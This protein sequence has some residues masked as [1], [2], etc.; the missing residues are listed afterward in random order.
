MIRTLSGGWSATPASGSAPD[1][2]ERLR[3]LVREIVDGSSTVHPQIG[4]AE[5]R[6]AGVSA[7]RRGAVV[8]IAS[9]KGGVG[10][11]SIAVNLSIALA[12]QHLRVVLLDGDLGLGNA[13]VLCGLNPE[14]N[15]GDLVEGTAS[16]EDITLDAPGGFRLVPGASGI[17]SLADLDG[18]SRERMLACLAR[19]ETGAD[20]LMIDCGAGIG[21]SVRAFLLSSDLPLV[22]VTPDPTSITDAYALIKSLHGASGGRPAA[23]ALVVNQARDREEAAGV[24]RRIDSVCARFLGISV[25]LAGWLRA[26]SEVAR[27]VRARVPFTIAQPSGRASSDIRDLCGFV[28]ALCGLGATRREERGGLVARL[29]RFVTA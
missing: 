11:T 12:A 16:L 3:A 9:G 10:K 13:D 15:L 1:Q 28:G 5:G 18:G 20:V 25:P 8:A 27:A 29:L 24:H 7:P 21:A 22:V 6:P 14:R 26:D 4:D 17:A 19:L 2:A 23:P